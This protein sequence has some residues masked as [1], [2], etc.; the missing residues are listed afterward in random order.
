M[1]AEVAE[2]VAQCLCTRGKSRVPQRTTLKFPRLP[3]K[4]FCYLDMDLVGE[5]PFTAHGYDGF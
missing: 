3:W 4:P 1:D 5:L 2:S